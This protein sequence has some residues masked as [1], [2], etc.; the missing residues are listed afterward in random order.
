MCGPAGEEL[1]ARK[2]G[3]LNFTAAAGLAPADALPLYLAGA[4]DPREAVSRRAEE[5]LRKRCALRKVVGC[6][7]LLPAVSG[8]REMLLCKPI[9]QS[10]SAPKL[11]LP[12]GFQIIR[13]VLGAPS[14]GAPGGGLGRCGAADVPLCY[15]LTTAMS[16]PGGL[17]A[18]LVILRSQICCVRVFR[19]STDGNRPAVDL[20][21][22]ALITRLF[23]LFHGTPEG[24]P[25][26]PAHERAM[27]AGPALQAR[28]M[29]MFTRSLAAANAFP[30]VLQARHA[31]VP[32]LLGVCGLP[33]SK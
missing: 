9:A 2:L 21:D 11:H 16:A 29:G 19:C 23:A 31:A 6:G 24:A 33:E 3:V 20:E 18:Q 22:A 12:A 25:G 32:A 15:S 14:A 26:V 10:R 5:L 30:A 8:C 13:R 7:V 27:P 28:L 17:C 1:E 4:A